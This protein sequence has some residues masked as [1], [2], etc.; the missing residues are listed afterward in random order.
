MAIDIDMAR[1]LTI[2]AFLME[3]G[4]IL[5]SREILQKDT[6]E[7]FLNDLNSYE[8]ISYVENIHTMMSSAQINALIFKHFNLNDMF[9]ESM[10]YLDNEK[11]APQNL[12]EMV[13]ALQTVRATINVRDQFNEYTLKH[14][15]E[16]LE[17]NNY[18]VDA[19]KRAIKRV[20]NRYN[21]S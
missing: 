13:F 10:K 14:T 11:E 5:I 7:S 4:K 8:D 19:F 1:E 17:K 15:L 12:K 9:I 16:L 2:I 20:K 21:Y 18:N 6:T 3:T